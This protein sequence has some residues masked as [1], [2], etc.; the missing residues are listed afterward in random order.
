[1]ADKNN[2]K[3]SLTQ[4]NRT[5][6]ED[7]ALA[8]QIDPN[9]QKNTETKETTQKAETWQDRVKA[10]TASDKD[11]ELA[12]EAYVAGKYT[13]GP[14]TKAYFEKHFDN[15]KQEEEPVIEDKPVTTGVKPEAEQKAVNRLFSIKG[16]DG[17]PIIEVAEDG[18]II[19]NK[20]MSKAEFIK[21]TGSKGNV[22]KGLL[23]GL[24][25]ALMALG[26]PCPNLGKTYEQISGN[27]VDEVYNQ[28]LE[29]VNEL[30]KTFS[31][32]VGEAYGDT[33][34]NR[35]KQANE[36]SDASNEDF[37]KAHNYFAKNEN[38]LKLMYESGQADIQKDL[39]DYFNSSDW[40]YKANEM[41]LSNALQKDLAN[42][43]NGLPLEQKISYFK[44]ISSMSEKDTKELGR[45]LANIDSSMS[46]D[47]KNQQIYDNT[48]GLVKDVG[49]S[50]VSGLMQGVGAGLTSDKNCKNFIMPKMFH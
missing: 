33:V 24:S 25:G 17:K 31:T 14:K 34:K 35:A 36:I 39:H 47:E 28:Y 2:G 9:V 37:M 41:N 40:T 13:P 29:Q 44:Y 22:V 3:T 30:Q 5:A 19:L 42:F 32:S 4:S 49:S 20:P 46:T 6:E 21:A 43:M 27:N 26:V 45:R 50:A 12:Y 16:V 38:E 11:M 23:T 7:R 15:P 8:E 18:S 48:V 10:G 1:M